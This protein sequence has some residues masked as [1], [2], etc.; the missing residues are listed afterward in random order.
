M[1][2]TETVFIVTGIFWGWFKGE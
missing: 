1:E 2:N